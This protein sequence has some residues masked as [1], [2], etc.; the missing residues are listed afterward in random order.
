M[1]VDWGR[2]KARGRCGLCTWKINAVASRL[3]AEQAFMSHY[4]QDHFVA[5]EEEEETHAV[6]SVGTDRP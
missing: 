2:G 1:S 3:A 4:M 6:T 5:P